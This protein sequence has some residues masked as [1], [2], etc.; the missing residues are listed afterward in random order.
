[1]KVQELMTQQVVSCYPWSNLSEVAMM[2]WNHDC[3]MIPVMSESGAVT[4][5]IT[6]RDICMGVATQHRRAEEI[7]VADVTNGA[8]YTCHPEDT[9]TN[10]LKLMQ[11]HQVRRLPVVDWDGHL[12][13]VLSLNNVIAASRTAKT[14]TYSEVIDTLKTIGKSQLSLP[15][16]PDL[17]VSGKS[18][19]TSLGERLKGKAWKPSKTSG[20]SS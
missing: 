7:T 13:G 4:G 20:L 2:M 8:L 19:T 11:D 10:A 14:P 18:K 12:V 17:Q 1:M 15:K 6:D 5:V 16:V 9:V 3:G